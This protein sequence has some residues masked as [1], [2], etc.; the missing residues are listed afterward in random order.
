MNVARL[1]VAG[2]QDGTLGMIHGGTYVCC[3]ATGE[4]FVNNQT[5]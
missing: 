3:A 5:S 4:S 1:D 2:F